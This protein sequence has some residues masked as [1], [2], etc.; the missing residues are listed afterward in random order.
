MTITLKEISKKH[1][2]LLM[3]Y[4]CFSLFE[5]TIRKTMNQGWYPNS[6]ILKLLYK[7]QGESL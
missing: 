2:E 3:R 7:I 4:L 6:I 1:F 5:L